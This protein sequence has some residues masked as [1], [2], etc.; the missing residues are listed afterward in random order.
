MMRSHPNQ[1]LK[2]AIATHP[3]N[4]AAIA[5]VLFLNASCDR[6]FKGDWG[7]LFFDV[8]LSKTNHRC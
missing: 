5:K 2:T 7:D 6:Y 4:Q 1:S 3:Q 8:R